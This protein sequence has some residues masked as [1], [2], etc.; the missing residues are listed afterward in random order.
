MPKHGAIPDFFPGRVRFPMVPNRTTCPSDLE[1]SAPSGKVDQDSLGF[2]EDKS[3]DP[4]TKCTRRRSVITGESVDDSSS[5]EEFLTIF[6]QSIFHTATRLIL[7]WV[8]RIIGVLTLWDEIFAIPQDVDMFCPANGQEGNA[9]LH[10]AFASSP[11]VPQCHRHAVHSV[12]QPNH[13]TDDW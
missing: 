8:R 6:I 9:P 3:T 13:D 7:T 11:D 2:N 4:L 1:L 12:K 5:R 10:L